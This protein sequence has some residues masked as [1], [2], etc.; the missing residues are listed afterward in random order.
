[1]KIGKYSYLVL[2]LATLLGLFAVATQNFGFCTDASILTMELSQKEGANAK[3]TFTLQT[4]LPT[5]PEKLWIYSMS[6]P[7]VS[8]ESTKK[9]AESR[10]KVAPT[11]LAEIST[12]TLAK[13]NTPSGISSSRL[14]TQAAP[15]SKLEA[16]P[17]ARLDTTKLQTLDQVVDLGTTISLATA[18]SYVSVDKTSAAETVILNVPSLAASRKAALPSEDVLKQKADAYAAANNLLPEGYQ[19]SGMSYLTRQE[20]GQGGVQG[21]V[22]QITG[23]AKYSRTIDGLV[24]EGPGS[25]ICV[26]LGEGGQPLGY[27]KVSRNIGA[28]IAESSVKAPGLLKTMATEEKT[29]EL[30]TPE[31]AFQM[32]Q[33]RGMTTEIADVNTATVDKMYLAYYEAEPDKKQ[34]ETEPVYVFEGTAT[35]PGGSVQYK[36][37]MYALRIK[38]AKA[39]F[40]M[41]SPAKAKE[42][43][44]DEPMTAG[45]KDPELLR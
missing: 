24:V 16:T 31:E 45:T 38:N 15:E 19:Y 21:P 12:P 18:E 14:K 26:M 22:E 4:S 30:L 35:G 5:V 7:T 6:V 33:E 25:T 34:V 40:E 3:P 10:L 20:I 11:K 13:I 17:V 42:R 28:K 44:A 39:P 32:L 8:I 36:E 1:M 41:S 23:I 27:T 9:L 29:F 2:G 43:K 37:F